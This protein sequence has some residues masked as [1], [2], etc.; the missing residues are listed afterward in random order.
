MRLPFWRRRTLS[1][2][3][4]NVW[5]GLEKPHRRWT[6]LLSILGS[7]QPDVIALREVT[8]P[9]LGMLRKAPWVRKRYEISDPTGDLLEGYGNLIVSR[10]PVES[11]SVHA[12][13]TEMDRK[14]VIVEASAAQGMWAFASV[15][16]ESFRESAD[17]RRRQLKQV[18]E[19]LEPYPD[20]ALMGDFNFC[21]SWT[22]ENNRIPGDYVDVWPAVRADDGFT[23]DT[24]LNEMRGREAE[25]TKRVRFDRVLIHSGRVTPLDAK[26]VGTKKIRGEKPALYP[27]DHC[28]LYVTLRV[29]DSQAAR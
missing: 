29:G 19:A 17:L 18:F 24:D 7:L 13:D 26:L 2:L 12:L 16:L 8:D 14:L 28:G 27:S 10:L 22:Q 25:T 1:L 6:E 15:H 20:V 3:S 23:V 4:W 9:F 5:F 11:A 21:A